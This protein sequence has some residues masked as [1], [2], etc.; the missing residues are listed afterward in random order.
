MTEPL[1][2]HAAKS[3]VFLKRGRRVRVNSGR[4]VTVEAS[5]WTDVKKGPRA[6]ECRRPLDE[7]GEGVDFPLKPPERTAALGAS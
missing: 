1:S 6:R 4:N 5:G 7:K 3:P 2:T